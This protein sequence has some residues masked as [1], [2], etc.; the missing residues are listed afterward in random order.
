M[1]ILFVQNPAIT[2]RPIRLKPKCSFCFDGRETTHSFEITATL[3]ISLVLAVLLSFRLLLLACA[4][5]YMLSASQ[6]QP[7]LLHVSTQY[8]QRSFWWTFQAKLTSCS[9]VNVGLVRFT[10]CVALQGDLDIYSKTA[11]KYDDCRLLHLPNIRLRFVDIPS[12]YF[13][14]SKFS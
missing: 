7:H 14:C 13:I 4:K 8:P 11:S 3:S 12:V 5:S 2:A 1:G 6:R 10:A 9:A